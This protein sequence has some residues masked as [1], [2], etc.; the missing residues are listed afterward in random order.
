VIAFIRDGSADA[1][2][3]FAAFRKGLYETVAALAARLPVVA[4]T[5]TY[6]RTQIGHQRRQVIVSAL[7]PVVLDHH[8]LAL[9]GALYCLIYY[10]QI[11]YMLNVGGAWNPGLAR[12]NRPLAA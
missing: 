1:N 10:C 12:E 8:V 2:A 4:I 6:R 5:A 11:R 9:D 7:Q 3:R